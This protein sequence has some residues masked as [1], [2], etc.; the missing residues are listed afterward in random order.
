MSIF[1]MQN[2][3][4]E[5]SSTDLNG[6]FLFA[7]LLLD[8]LLDLEPPFSNKEKFTRKCAKLYEKNAKELEVLADFNTN[9][10]ATEVLEWYTR[11]C[12]IFKLL[13]KALRRQN[14]SCLLYTSPSPRDR[15]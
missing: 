10:C 11:E 12:F 7:Q 6:R 2:V 13:N 8:I 15:G 5:H 3:S 14:I 1:N 4:A 9:Y